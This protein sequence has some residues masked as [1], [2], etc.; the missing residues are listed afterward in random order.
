VRW[1]EGDDVRGMVNLVNGSDFR[2]FRKTAMVSTALL[3]LM[4][5]LL[6]VL[7]IFPVAKAAYVSLTVSGISVPASIEPGESGNLVL[8]IENSGTEYARSVKL[9]ISP[10]SM[11]SFGTSQYSLQTIAPGSS[12]QVSVP[13]T[14]SSSATEGAT[15]VFLSVEYNE[16]SSTGSV[17][18]QSSVSVS[19]TKRSLIE[20]TNVSYNDQLIEQGDV[21]KMVVQLKN[22]G[23]G[24]I[25]DMVVALKNRSQPFVSAGGDMERY[26][27]SLQPNQYATADFDIIINKDAETKAYSVPVTLT[28]Y[29]ESGAVHAEERYVGLKVSGLPDFVVTLESQ[30]NMYAGSAGEL[31]VSV[32]NRGTATAAYLLANFDS[33]YDIIPKEYYIGD[34]DQD[35]YETITLDISLKGVAA[36]KHSLGINLSYKDPYNQELAAAESVDFTVQPQPAFSFSLMQTIIMA[37]LAVI[38]IWK[39]KFLRSLGV[40]LLKRK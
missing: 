15:S 26:L 24:R 4:F 36:G 40:R 25:K 39:R 17:T 8:T 6:F 28:Y 1:H 2:N 38:I 14:V 31:T 18:T 16:G 21:V 9:V 5:S 7:F 3:G 30:S 22:V 37:A 34:L 11:I 35:S 19:I 32:A 12:T 20:I 27:G 33:T 10:H 13:M 23:S 29:D